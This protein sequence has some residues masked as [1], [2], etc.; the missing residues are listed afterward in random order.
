M[1]C[2]IPNHDNPAPVPTW[3]ADL[4]GYDTAP[5]IRFFLHAI[6]R[7]WAVWPCKGGKR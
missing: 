4:S 6:L 5:D 3:H 7:Y 1:A 2:L